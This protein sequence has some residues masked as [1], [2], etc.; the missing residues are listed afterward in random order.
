[1]LEL[2]TRA[3]NRKSVGR[4]LRVTKI[5]IEQAVLIKAPGIKSEKS[6]VSHRATLGCSLGAELGRLLG[7]TEGP[8]DGPDVGMFVGS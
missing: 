1:L 8:A 5:D 3:G 2:N 6:Q 7:L 4:I